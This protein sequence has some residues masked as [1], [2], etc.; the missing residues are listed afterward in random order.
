MAVRRLYPIL[1][2]VV[3]AAGGVARLAIAGEVP[4]RPAERPGDNCSYTATP[5]SLH[6]PDSNTRREVYDQA[7]AFE[8]AVPQRQRGRGAVAASTLARHNLIDQEIFQRLE[9]GGIPAAP[10]S[11]DEEFLRRVDLD[12]TG[13]IPSANEVRAFVADQ[14]PKKRDVLVDRLLHSPEFV[15]KWTVWMGDLL[16]NTMR[17]SNRDEGVPGRNGV[18]KYIRE[19]IEQDRSWREIAFHMLTATGN[20]YDEDSAGVN[21]VVRGFAPM[22]EVHALKVFPGGR[23]SDRRTSTG[24]RR[25]AAVRLAGTRQEQGAAFRRRTATQQPP[26]LTEK[27]DTVERTTYRRT[28]WQQSHLL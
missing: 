12:L 7:L 27:Q 17:A 28:D 11:T 6:A 10:L 24:Q 20:S 4:P 23:F 14:T 2:R 22:A 26:L 19:S 25:R 21:F 1:L 8:K 16:Q 13:R 5:R 9:A 15:D 18:Y 3:L